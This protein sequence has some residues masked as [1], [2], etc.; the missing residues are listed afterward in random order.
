[1]VLHVGRLQRWRGFRG[2]VA[3][4]LC[5]S[6]ATRV[7]RTCPSSVMQSGRASSAPRPAPR[8]KFDLRVAMTLMQRYQ[9][10]PL[11]AEEW[12]IGLLPLSLLRRT[13]GSEDF[14]DKLRLAGKSANIYYRAPNAHTRTNERIDAG[15]QRFR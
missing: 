1:M 10:K 4:W 9:R 6:P 13:S 12:P 7:A 3:S 8:Y 11:S 14:I 2:S 15:L 5:L